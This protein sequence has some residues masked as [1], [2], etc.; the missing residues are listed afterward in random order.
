MVAQYNSESLKVLIVTVNH[1]RISVRYLQLQYSYL[2]LSTHNRSSI[3]LWRT[4]LR[5][6]YSLIF[7]LNVCKLGDYLS[8]AES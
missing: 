5:N 2:A 4:L 3:K 6:R 8:S 7:R 1:Y